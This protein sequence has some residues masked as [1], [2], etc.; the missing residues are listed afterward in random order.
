MSAAA[1]KRSL[2]GKLLVA[3]PELR[4]PHFFQTLVFIAHHDAEGALGF[5][6]NRPV[7]ASLAEC[8]GTN[9]QTRPFFDNIPVLRGGP[10]GG[11]RLAVVVFERPPRRKQLVAHL[12]LP[13]DQ[14]EAC[15][16]KPN[17]WVRAFHGHAGWDEGQ[18]ERELAEGSWVVKPPDPVILNPRIA[19][20]LWPF[21]IS[22]DDRWRALLDYL[23]EESGRN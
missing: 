9:E 22:G 21:V 4:D 7:G 23:P 17:A 11:A 6:M 1:A 18:L 8:I 2:A 15:L 13:V 20:G 14:L 16:A 10:V 3:R 19:E 5:V 12:G